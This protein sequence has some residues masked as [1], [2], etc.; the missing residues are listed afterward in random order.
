MRMSPMTK[1]RGRLLPLAMAAALVAGATTAVLAAGAA[2][3]NDAV[4]L[5]GAVQKRLTIRGS[6]GRESVTIS[7]AAAG[8]LTLHATDRTFTSMRTDCTVPGISTDALCDSNY[9]KVDVTFSRGGD[10]LLFDGFDVEGLVRVLAA[11][12][13]GG[14][15]LLGSATHDR[16]D[17][18]VGDDTLRGKAGR[19]ELDGGD[20]RDDCEGGSGDDDVRNCE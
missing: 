20:G 5:E 9:E 10:K 18:G 17:G 6:D 8:A 12:G 15:R 19:D 4:T 7:G 1:T 2:P 11:G 14:D 3:T 16:F 13:A